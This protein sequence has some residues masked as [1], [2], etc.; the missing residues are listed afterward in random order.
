VFY[1]PGVHPALWGADYR[2][3]DEPMDVWWK[4][5]FERVANCN[6]D[7][8]IIATDSVGSPHTGRV[9]L[10]RLGELP[11]DKAVTV[12]VDDSHGL[13]IFGEQG[14]GSYPALAGSIHSRHKLLVVSS[15]NK[16]LGVPAG[17]VFSDEKT[18]ASL[19]HSPFFGGSSPAVP[20]ALW[21]LT[22]AFDLYRWQHAK[23]MENT[24]FFVENLGE[25]VDQF[26]RMP[27]YPAFTTTAEGFHEFLAKNGILTAS[28]SYPT[29]ADPPITRLVVS[30]LHTYG[31]LETVAKIC[32]HFFLEHG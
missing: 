1:A 7:E 24:R 8:I 20:G 28:F 11:A 6:P 23:L 4:K 14:V 9:P 2:P 29:P 27:G 15:L 16:A 10:E 21:A 5:L 22:R 13:G 32:Q 18:I 26:C 31:D 3:A 25:T 17:V 30:A 19:R 12:V